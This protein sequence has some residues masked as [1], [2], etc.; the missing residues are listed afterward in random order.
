M[1]MGRAELF[2]SDGISGGR[3]WATYRRK[4]GTGS[5]Q[6]FKSP[7]LPCRPTREEAERDLAAYL[8]RKERG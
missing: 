7:A 3:W 8:A 5:L 1:K 6:R 4:P 2:V